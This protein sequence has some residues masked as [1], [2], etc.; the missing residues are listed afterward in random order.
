MK[1]KPLSQSELR[2]LEKQ[3]SDVVFGKAKSKDVYKR[4][5][6]EIRRARY[7]FNTEVEIR[8]RL[9]VA[10]FEIFEHPNRAE[11]QCLAVL[12]K[13]P[14]CVGAMYEMASVVRKRNDFSAA[15]HWLEKAKQISERNHDYLGKLEAL[16]RMIWTAEAR[17]TTVILDEM[18][19]LLR[20]APDIKATQTM[21]SYSLVF[22]NRGVEAISYLEELVVHLLK[23]GV[24]FGYLRISIMNLVA[25]YSQNGMTSVEARKKVEQFSEY[26]INDDRREHFNSAVTF[27][28]DPK[29]YPVLETYRMNAEWFDTN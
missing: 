23:L 19:S 26:C 10:G 22:N 21:G 27:A 2:E 24:T 13:Q 3:A 29:Q 16:D 17:N 6:K 9:M 20:M 1:L 15:L 7:S 8:L 12:R 14:E 4:L 18:R 11:K 28:F 5:R 25:A